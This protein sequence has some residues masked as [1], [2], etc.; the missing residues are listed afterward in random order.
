[1]DAAF[2]STTLSFFDHAL[3]LG[4]RLQSQGQRSRATQVMR[5]LATNRHLSP[6]TAEEARSQLAQNLLEDGEYRQARRQFTA[7][8]TQQPRNP[9]YHFQ[10]GQAIAFDDSVDHRRALRHLQRA[11]RLDPRNAEY[12]SEFGL[13]ALDL[14]QTQAGLRALRKAVKLA[15]DEP[16]ILEKAMDGL[17]F[18]NR[19]EEARS[20]LRTARFRHPRDPRFMKLWNDLHFQEILAEQEAGRARFELNEGRPALL[21]FDPARAT[22]GY[23]RDHASRLGTPHLGTPADKKQ[24]R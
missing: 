19:H 16:S 15:P 17:L 10:M 14:G 1:M 3:A 18:E 24:I 20:M 4:R 8:L 12:L 9:Q 2:Q 6:Q 5:R 23:R 22:K 21:P 13:L 7:L 11:V